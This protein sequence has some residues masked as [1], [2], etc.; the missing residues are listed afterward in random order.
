LIAEDPSEAV[1]SEDIMAVLHKELEVIYY[2][3]TGGTLLQPVV[4]G[5]AA[6][7]EIVP[8]GR[9]VLQ[10]LIEMEKKLMAEGAIPSDYMFCVAKRKSTPIDT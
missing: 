3:N 2:K 9:E 1:R 8:G 6:N 10:E 7:F 4:D 5:I